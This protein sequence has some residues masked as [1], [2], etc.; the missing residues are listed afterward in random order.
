MYVTLICD[1][2]ALVCI[3]MHTYVCTHRD[4]HIT[5]LR[6]IRS[7]MN[8]YTKINHIH[9]RFGSKQKEDQS[10]NNYQETYRN[11]EFSIILYIVN[12]KKITPVTN[13]LSTIHEDQMQNIYIKS[14]WQPQSEWIDN[15]LLVHWKVKI[16]QSKPS[17]TRELKTKKKI[18]RKTRRY[19]WIW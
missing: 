12:G 14:P 17:K 1:C 16:N 19:F 5:M 3:C 6:Q 10:P 15:W 2:C 9:F 4:M 11:Y 8:I 13:H 18:I 7:L